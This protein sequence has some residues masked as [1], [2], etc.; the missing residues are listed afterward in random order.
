MR[1]WPLFRRKPSE[2]ADKGLEERL[3]ALEE[4]WNTIEAEWTDWYEKFRLLHLRLAH[5]QKALEKSEALA[6]SVQPD[7]TNGGEGSEES[8]PSI[9]FGGLKL[10]AHQVEMQKQVLRRRS[11]L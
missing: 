5:R 4:R 10:D 11:R 2:G 3:T 6:T 8:L 1:F 9:A 7:T